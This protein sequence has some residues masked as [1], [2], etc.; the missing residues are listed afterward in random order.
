VFLPLRHESME[1]RRWPV[2]SI[3]L[4][5][6]NLLIF[7][8]TH[9]RIEQENPQRGQTRSHILMLAAMHPEL[10]M[11]PDA[12]ELVTSF[13]RDYPA[14]WA[15]AK[16]GNRE[17]EDVWDAKMRLM[18]DPSVLQAEM[19]SLCSEY[20]TQAGQSILEK[21]A[22][23]PAHPSGISYLTANFLHGGWL[24]LI[25]NMWF[26][27]LAGVILE[28]TWGRIIYPI[29]YLV[30]G[31]AALQLHA[32]FN[33]GSLTPTLGASGAVAALMGAFLV[34]FPTT[35]IDVAVILSLRSIANLAMGKGFRFKAAAYWLLPFWLLAEVFSGTIFGKYSGTA[36]WAHVGGFAFGALGALALRYSGLEAKAD[37]AIESKV[38]WT[39]APAIV[40]ATE[41]LEKGKLDDAIRTLQT[42][43]ASS[44]ESVEGYTLLQQIQWRKNNVPA[45]RDAMAKLIQLHLKAQNFEAAWQD[46]Q[47]LRNSGAETLP[48][49]IW[50][51]LGR[52]AEGQGNFERAVEEYGRLAAAFPNER[53]ALLALLS[54][55][56]LSL[57]NLNRPSDALRFYENA[58][59]SPVPHSDWDT[60]IRNGIEGAKKA[61]GPVPA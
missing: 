6:L 38:T 57:K 44:P 50:L 11:S 39:A 48:S 37:A 21:Y 32:W 61:L 58:A 10:T 22:F 34:R 2:I 53:P 47:D 52:A 54:A 14:A 5:V 28:D 55:G 33:A 29:F 9:G 27:W 42:Y 20:A 41:Q 40:Q 49:T 43:L 51:E 26:L 8:G 31:A 23:V 7:L 3:A 15:N 59:K 25:G 36:H 60:N 16:S 17:V 1:G 18:E 45:Y 46:Y 19:D 35:K 24:H 56:R 4:V 12:Q 30:A 13:Q